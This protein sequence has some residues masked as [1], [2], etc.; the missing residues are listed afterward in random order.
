MH[1]QCRRIPSASLLRRVSCA[2]A[3]VAFL[4]CAVSPASATIVERF[5]ED[6]LSGAGSRIFFIE[7]DADARFT[8][9][10]DTRPRFAGDRRGTLRVLYDTTAPQARISTPLGEILSVDDD[11]TFGAILTIRSEGFFASPTGFSQIAFGLWNSSTTGLNRTGF[12][13]DS[14]DLVEFDYFP[15]AGEFGGPFLTPSIFGGNVSDNAFFNFAF[16]SSEVALP[17]DVPLLCTISY[18]AAERRLRL[19]VAAHEG[20]VRFREVVDA[21]VLV[22]L[23]ILD[24]TFLVNSLG[25]AAY[26]EG[27]VSSLRAQVD[28]DLL[29]FGSLP[30]PLR[31]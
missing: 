7:G 8:Y 11:F 23:S 14:Y 9:L 26:F 30:K 28:Y 5:E 2:I 31:P 24:P 16:Q 1:R 19:T 25:I 15:N 29:F 20:G 12:P 21:S 6:P 17:F 3:F 27:V 22:D 18:R 13:A 10:P 4:L